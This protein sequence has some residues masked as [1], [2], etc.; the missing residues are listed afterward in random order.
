MSAESEVQ[1]L[2]NVDPDEDWGST[3]PLLSNDADA[4]SNGLR[5]A[6]I[7][8]DGDDDDGDG[9]GNENVGGDDRK[10]ITFIETDVRPREYY[11]IL[12]AAIFTMN[13]ILLVLGSYFFEWSD[14]L[15][16]VEVNTLLL[17]DTATSTNDQ[18]GVGNISFELGQTL[19][20]DLP[21]YK[22]ATFQTTLGIFQSSHSNLI[23]FLIIASCIVAPAIYMLIHPLLL[24]VISSLTFKKISPSLSLTETTM[25]DNPYDNTNTNTRTVQVQRKLCHLSKMVY[26]KFSKR[27]GYL[28]SLLEFFM[29][30]SMALIF[31][32]SILAICTSKVTF[33]IGNDYGPGSSTSITSEVNARDEDGRGG[34]QNRDSIYA[35]VINRA[36]G[37]LISYLIGLSFFGIGTLIILR[38]QWKDTKKKHMYHYQQQQRQ[39]Q[40]QH[41]SRN[42]SNDEAIV[43]ALNNGSD[44]IF[45]PPPSAFQQHQDYFLDSSHSDFSEDNGVLGVMDDDHRSIKVSLDD[46]DVDSN[47]QMSP[48]LS[49]DYHNHDNDNDNNVNM[50]NEV[51]EIDGRYGNQRKWPPIL[52]ILQ[53]EFGLLSFILLLPIITLPLIRLE[54][55][56][57]FSAL[58]DTDT[59]LKET[60]LSLWD[61]ARSIISANNNGRDIFGLVS[62][63]FFWINVIIIPITNWILSATVWVFSFLYRGENRTISTIATKAYMLLKFFQPFAFMTPFAISLFVTVSSLQQV[64]DFL[65]NQ[66]GACQMIQNVL[67]LDESTEECMIMKG[68]LLPGSYVL[69]LQGLFT[70]F[71]VVLVAIKCK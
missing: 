5:A 31:V 40:Q 34:E 60:T 10:A 38:K 70:D 65:F 7:R 16:R 29:K 57:L 47:D 15:L 37:G 71:F 50:I 68:H 28:L 4:N 58:L 46:R 59:T 8:A 20:V 55:T 53:F 51:N 43:L 18:E 6:S 24:I 44:T 64:T 54:Y 48:L 56:G 35:H 21:L 66:N 9:D 63:A 25:S 62:I 19:S 33:V 45:S 61:I 67:G 22:D 41:L 1:R 13:F 49:S 11:Q 23:V 32:N 36:R 12:L 17:N 39:Q 14:T 52:E 3:S 30:Y 69:L 42:N 26:R 2:L 27:I